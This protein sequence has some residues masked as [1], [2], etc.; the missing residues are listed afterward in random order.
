M[1]TLQQIITEADILVPN[2]YANPD[3]VAWLN[4]I[5]QDFF[6]VVKIPQAVTFNASG[7]QPHYTLP[8]NTR[9]KNIDQVRVGLIQYRSL[10]SED[11]KPG[12]NYWTFN[13]SNFQLTL[14]PPPAMSGQGVVRCYRVGTTTFTSNSLNVQP[15]APPE[16][17]WIYTIG[18]CSK[19][20]KAQ[21]DIAKANNYASEF[22]NALNVAAQN[23]AK[24]GD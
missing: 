5:N 17:H 6:S 4:A 19:I 21:D 18:L 22:T 9:A 8:N 13:D 2:A 20:A 15:D 24:L 11:V 3:K 23:H 7:N 1:L 14:T 12:Q 16:Y 10:L